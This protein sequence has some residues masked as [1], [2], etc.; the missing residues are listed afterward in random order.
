MKIRNVRY[1]LLRHTLARKYGDAQGLK[2]HRTSLLVRLDTDDGISGWGDISNTRNDAN[3]LHLG[4]AR[5]LLI[6]QDPRA[7][8]PLVRQ[9]AVFGPRI[10]AGIEVALADIRGMAAG[11]NL[12]TLLG[13]AFRARQPCYASLQN[14]NDEKDIDANAVRQATH[15]A[16]LGFRHVKMKVGWH[17]P[18]SMRAGSTRC[19]R[20][21]RQR[22][23][24][25]STPTA[26]WTWRP[27]SASSVV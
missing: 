11:M 6:G 7:A 21:C 15:A 17:P 22:C 10:A 20:L 8:S 27:P 12:A 19:S 13:G 5:D 2:T 4:E 9:L 25:R 1:T 18:T 24:S 16:A 26:C 14:A 23:R 3:L